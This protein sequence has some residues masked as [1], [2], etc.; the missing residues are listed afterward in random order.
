MRDEF[1]LLREKMS[2]RS[3]ERIFLGTTVIVILVSLNLGLSLFSLLPVVASP[4]ALTTHTSEVGD[5]ISSLYDRVEQSVVQI[6]SI[7]RI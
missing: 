6:S 7:Q 1:S 3:F 4:T 5:Q 2:N